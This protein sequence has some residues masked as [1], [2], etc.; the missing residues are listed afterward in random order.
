MYF[1]EHHEPHFY[2]FNSFG[3]DFL[4]NEGVSLYLL[5]LPYQARDLILVCL[6]LFFQRSYQL[7][8]KAFV[9]EICGFPVS[10][11]PQ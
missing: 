10:D 3:A 11:S 2:P 1:R 4:E 8:M 6:L 7:L 5:R 9:G